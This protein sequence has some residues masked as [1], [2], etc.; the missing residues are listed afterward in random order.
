MKLNFW[1]GKG[2]YPI[3]RVKVI[4]IFVLSRLWYRSNIWDIS[5][6]MLDTLNR[7]VRNFIWEEKT[8][9][10]VR[11]EVLQLSYEKGGLQLV[12]IGCKMQVQ[13]IKSILYLLNQDSNNIERFLADSLID[14]FLRHKQYGLSFGLF[15]NKTRIQNVKSCFYK[16]ALK[17]IMDL[18][19]DRQILIA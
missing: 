10:R 1:K 13:R 11:Q 6:N 19:L 2:L 8:G 5:K 3:S 16:N 17:I 15:N 14:D 7:L 9:A 4:N 18:N 12:D